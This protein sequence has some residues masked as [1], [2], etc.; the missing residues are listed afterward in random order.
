MHHKNLWFCI[1]NNDGKHSLCILHQELSQR[2]TPSRQCCQLIIS[3]CCVRQEM[4]VLIVTKTFVSWQQ[5]L[6]RL[7][8]VDV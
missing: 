3:D 5:R 4:S 6:I 1:E 8:R 2:V 7:L